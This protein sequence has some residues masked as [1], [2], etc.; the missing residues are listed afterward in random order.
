MPTSGP[1]NQGAGSFYGLLSQYGLT[2][3]VTGSAGGV[4]YNIAQAPLY[5]VRSGLITM[6]GEWID[7]NDDVMEGI[8]VGV[9]IQGFLW[10]SYAY[11]HISVGRNL[12]FYSTGVYPSSGGDRFYAFSLRCLSTVLDR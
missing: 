8:L 9:G 5:F 4:S 1:D 12:Y 2:S 10:S 7:I 11:S 3:S 6:S